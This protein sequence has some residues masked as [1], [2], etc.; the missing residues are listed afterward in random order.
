MVMS[1][2]SYLMSAPV[3]LASCSVAWSERWTNGLE[4]ELLL[5]RERRNP[6]FAHQLTELGPNPKHDKFVTVCN[7]PFALYRL[8]GPLP[9]VVPRRDEVPPPVLKLWTDDL[10]PERGASAFFAGASSRALR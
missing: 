10:D 2:G 8:D 4:A 1:S 9:L 5:A 3:A 7:S 6:I